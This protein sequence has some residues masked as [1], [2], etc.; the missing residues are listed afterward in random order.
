ME[1]INMSI[2]E[3]LKNRRV[4]LSIKQEDVAE[5]MDVTVQTVSKW[6]RDIT[7]PKA[8][9]VAMLSK[10]LNISEKE[11]CEGEVKNKAKGDVLD[12]ITRVGKVINQVS[13]TDLLVIL[14]N[15]IEDTEEFIEDISRTAGTPF[16]TEN[17]TLIYQAKKNLKLANGTSII[18]DNEEEKENFIKANEA[19]IKQ[20]VSK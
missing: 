17:E 18:W 13:T 19:I 20:C 4:S 11:I 2:G 14:S 15:H 5:R 16:S 9:Q 12:F 1:R 8:K 3:V 7:E 6:E 10:I